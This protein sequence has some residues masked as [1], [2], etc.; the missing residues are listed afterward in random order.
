MRAASLGD[1]P[2]AMD[3]A[4]PSCL[5]DNL[6]GFFFVFSG[7]S[8]APVLLR[9]SAAMSLGIAAKGWVGAVS[10]VEGGASF[11]CIPASTLE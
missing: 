11:V 4:K 9:Y 5:G 6:E 7:G 10:G 1:M 8:G 3:R 2:L